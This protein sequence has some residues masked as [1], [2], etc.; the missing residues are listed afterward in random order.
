[1]TD[2]AEMFGVAVESIESK[3]EDLAV[4]ITEEDDALAR[5]KAELSKRQEQLDQA[6]EE[7]ANLLLS[8]GMEK[9]S[10]SNGLTPKA[11]VKEK[12]FKAAG[13]SDEHLFDWL[14]D[15]ELAD[16]IKPTVHFSTLQSTLKQFRDGGNEIPR[17]MFNCTEYS[18]IVLY[19]KS[20]FL[21]SRT[22]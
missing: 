3:V 16:I 11:V 9:V 17:D 4:H 22:A 13:V 12:I 5:L 20:K 7:L 1:M 18:T 6:K 14:K 15:H 2:V 10:L 21:A 8:N 19:G